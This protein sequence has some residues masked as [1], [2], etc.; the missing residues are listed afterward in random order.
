MRDMRRLDHYRF[1]GFPAKTTH[2]QVSDRCNIMDGMAPSWAPQKIR[3]Q[4]QSHHLPPPIGHSLGQTGHTRHHTGHKIHLIARPDNGLSPCET[5]VIF[6]LFQ[7]GQLIFRS[8]GANGAMSYLAI[9]TFNMR[10]EFWLNGHN[11][12]FS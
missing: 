7:C 12:P 3:R 8:M 4:Q 11:V 9:A 1:E 2:H 10:R 6:D 5:A